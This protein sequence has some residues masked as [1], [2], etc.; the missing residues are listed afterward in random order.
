[1]FCVA[2]ESGSVQVQAAVLLLAKS[3]VTAREEQESKMSSIKIQRSLIM[4]FVLAISVMLLGRDPLVI[5][6]SQARH[7]VDP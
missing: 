1:M 6:S 4:I 7:S 3:V 2:G 5:V